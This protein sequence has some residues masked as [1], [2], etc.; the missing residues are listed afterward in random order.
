[1]KFFWA[2]S[3]LGLARSAS[4]VQLN[5]SLLVLHAAFSPHSGPGRV[6]LVL[7]TITGL[8]K[9]SINFPFPLTVTTAKNKS[10][11]SL[12]ETPWTLWSNSSSLATEPTVKTLH[13]CGS[14]PSDTQT[15]ATAEIIDTPGL[16]PRLPQPS[17]E[18][19][20]S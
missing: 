7:H 6:V 11:G 13:F 4:T 19:G 16:S 17:V 2:S 3:V 12:L 8:F 5:P 18:P 9:T 20:L 14:D 1:M 15:G 10:R